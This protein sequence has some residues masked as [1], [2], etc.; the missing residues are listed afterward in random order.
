ML[1]FPESC[2]PVLSANP[3][4]LLRLYL[5]HSYRGAPKTLVWIEC[6]LFF[7]SACMPISCKMGGSP[8]KNMHPKWPQRIDQPR[9]TVDEC[10]SRMPPNFAIFNMVP[11]MQTNVGVISQQFLWLCSAIPGSQQNL[12][13]HLIRIPFLEISW[14]SQEIQHTNCFETHGISDFHGFS[15]NFQFEIPVAGIN[16]WNEHAGIS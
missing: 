16:F 10:T 14:N 7:G 12:I 8:Q 1:S 11:P 6:I 13:L 9:Q 4:E 15:S 2:F 5:V 3:Y